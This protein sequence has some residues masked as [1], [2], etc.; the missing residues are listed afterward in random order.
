MVAATTFTYYLFSSIN[1]KQISVKETF[2][3]NHLSKSRCLRHPTLH[4]LPGVCSSCLRERLQ[5]LLVQSENRFSCSSWMQ[6]SSSSDFSSDGGSSSPPE[7]VVSRRHQRRNELEA[8]LRSMSLGSG[9]SSSNGGGGGGFRKSR[10]IAFA[11]R[12]KSSAGV[13]GD[14]TTSSKK[15]KRRGFWSKLFHFKSIITRDHHR[16]AAGI[17]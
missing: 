16:Q 4:P 2:M 11:V 5:G 6:T 10:S 7:A 17:Y 9:E 1:M 8:V 12:N 14:P 3:A 13:A 15:K